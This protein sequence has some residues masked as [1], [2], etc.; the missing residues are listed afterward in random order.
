MATTGS[1]PMDERAISPPSPNAPTGLVIWICEGTKRNHRQIEVVNDNELIVRAF[2]EY[3]RSLG[4]EEERLRARVQCS[5]E[6]VKPEEARWSKITDIP[7]TQFTKP[8]V[9]VGKPIVKVGKR[10]KRKSNS[11]IVRY[12]SQS[13]KKQLCSE[14]RRFGLLP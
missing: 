1:A 13:L 14:G 10:V 2:L 11:V 8:I 4:I 12:S 6:D 5:A 3:L 7:I 9:K